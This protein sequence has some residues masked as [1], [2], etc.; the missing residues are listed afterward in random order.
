MRAARAAGIEF[1]VHEYE[2]DPAHPSYG[3]EAAERTGVD[4]AR[5]FK[6]LVATS[7]GSCAS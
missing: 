2:H 6:T 4:A 5:I 1:R 3:L 7:T